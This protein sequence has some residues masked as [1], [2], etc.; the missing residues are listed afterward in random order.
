[1]A[2]E[3]ISVG[4]NTPEGAGDYPFGTKDFVFKELELISSSGITHGLKQVVIEM[5][6]F[7][8]IYDSAMTG[9]II[10]NDANDIFSNFDLCGNEYLKVVIDKPGLNLPFERIFRI[11]QATSRSPVNDS[12]QVYMLHFCSDELVSSKSLLVSKAYK[13][14]KI[15][16][17]IF[18]I[19][20][21]ELNVD[22]KRIFK[23]EETS[24]V[25]DMIIPG[26]TPFEA[27]Q[28]AVSRAYDQNKFCYF[29]FENKNGFVM[30]SLQSLI[31]QTAYKTLKYE[32]KNS[33]QEEG[34]LPA[35]PSENKD[36]IDNLRIVSDFDVITSMTNG[37]FA[38]RLL[39][40]DLF[41]QTYDYIDY[42]LEVA[43]AKGNLINKYKPFN[44]LKN[45]KNESPFQA[46]GSF[47]RT[48]LA[49]NDTSSEK[50]NDIKYWLQPRALHLALLNNF[51]IEIDIPG[52][53]EL[54]AGDIVNYEFPLFESA[55]SGGK[56]MDKKRSGKYLVTA[57][58]HK[59]REQSFESTVLLSSDSFSKPLPVAKDG[60]G[61]LTKKGK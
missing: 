61:R 60:L 17:I 52:D 28:W 15:K 57:V 9:N 26:F 25:F 21:K 1:M 5:Q 35:D 43:E 48:N 34:N 59:F 8:N 30:S 16:D 33:P 31:K 37:A 46:F 4:Q 47:F 49:I 40:I 58:C 19:L 24:G 36:S 11:T 39:S 14:T 20:T 29:F 7:Q 6:I 44:N 55:T 51:Q 22:T 3:D 56:K 12:S 41:H 32:I 13:S 54:K 53:I 27:I 10:I 2:G 38:S 45:S 23:L 18:D 50:S 42:S